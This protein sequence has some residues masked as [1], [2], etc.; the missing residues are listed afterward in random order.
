MVLKRLWLGVQGMF[1]LERWVQSCPPGMG[2][3]PIWPDSLSLQTLLQGRG[4]VGERGR[5]IGGHSSVCDVQPVTAP[6]P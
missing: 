6:P 1:M 2:R 4:R 5:E 3:W